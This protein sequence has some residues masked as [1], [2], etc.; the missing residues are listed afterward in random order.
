MGERS[1]DKLAVTIQGT[2]D[3]EQTENPR[4]ILVDFV[5]AAQQC[6]KQ[7]WINCGH[8]GVSEAYEL[9]V[10]LMSKF[11]GL[12]INCQQNRKE[13]LKRH[14]IVSIGTTDRPEFKSCPIHASDGQSHKNN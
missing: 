14:L 7:F 5:H 11:P 8:F 12:G 13:G 4:Y 9:V 2:K 3:N 10:E 6:L 1:R